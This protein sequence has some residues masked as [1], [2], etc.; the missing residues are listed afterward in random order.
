M[1]TF[2]SLPVA[3]VDDDADVRDALSLLLR[4]HGFAVSTYESGE[5]FL[6]APE[7]RSAGCVILDVRM[8]AMSGPETFDRLRAA[9][10]ERVVVFL[11]G[12]GDIPLAVDM[13]KNGAFDFLEKPCRED[14][15]FERIAQ[16]LA[17]AQARL[18]LKETQEA[19]QSRLARLSAREREVMDKVL[20]GKLNKQ[21]AD[22]LNITMRT[23]EVH[24]ASV[25]A[26]MG[27][28]SALEL[29][30]LVAGQRGE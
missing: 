21:I 22:E 5:D 30:R 19:V 3:L 9:Q 23:V 6:A 11:S 4:S 20:S 16:A 8:P 25:F 12:H 29:S 28:K 7:S 24:R 2:T 14:V 13:V 27:V 18:G 17:I 15:L 26:K 1:T 10:S